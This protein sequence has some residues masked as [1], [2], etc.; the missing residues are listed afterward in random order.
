[1]RSKDTLVSTFITSF[2]QELNSESMEPISKL[3]VHS[4][5]ERKLQY[6]SFCIIEKYHRI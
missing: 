5:R 3:N 4:I 1:M 6:I 2:I